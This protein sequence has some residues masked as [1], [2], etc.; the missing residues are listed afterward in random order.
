MRPGIFA[1]TVRTPVLNGPF[2]LI[3]RFYGKLCAAKSG[4]IG[5][6]NCGFYV[7]FWMIKGMNLQTNSVGRM[8]YH[9]MMYERGS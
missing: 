9:L 1:R 8:V 2:Q 5:F 4:R 6:R 7:Y 3:H